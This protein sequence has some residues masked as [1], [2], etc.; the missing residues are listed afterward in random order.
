[1]VSVPL[2]NVKPGPGSTLAASRPQASTMGL[3]DPLG[4]TFECVLPPAAPFSFVEAK[5]YVESIPME[6]EDE[7]SSGLSATNQVVNGPFPCPSRIRI[8]QGKGQSSPLLGRTPHLL[9][10]PVSSSRWPHSPWAAPPGDGGVSG[11]GV[12][13]TRTAWEGSTS[14]RGPVV[15]I[16][17]HTPLPLGISCGY[18]QATR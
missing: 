14:T 5:A 12:R 16:R 2:K 10:R 7:L 1:M 3:L 11:E 13:G 15:A 4:L 9:L 6:S 18:F 8:R 17:T